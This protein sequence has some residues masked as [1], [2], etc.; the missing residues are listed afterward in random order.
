MIIGLKRESQELERRYYGYVLESLPNNVDPDRCG[1]G[2]DQAC[3]EAE[4]ACEEYA[5]TWNDAAYHEGDT[6]RKRMGLPANQP[7]EDEILLSQL[8]WE[9]AKRIDDAWAD[10][11]RVRH[12]EL[13]ADAG[14]Q[15]KHATTCCRRHGDRS[16]SARP[17]CWLE[18]RQKPRVGVRRT[19]PP[20][21]TGRSGFYG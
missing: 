12:P 16:P 6:I 17:E 7:P 21:P 9:S 3:R 14:R 15:Q 1:N 8:S 11:D 19:R 13:E 10:M 20:R 4:Y 5:R 2:D 18:P